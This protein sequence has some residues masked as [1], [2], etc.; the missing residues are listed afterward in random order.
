MA[1]CVCWDRGIISVAGKEIAVSEM[2]KFNVLFAL[3][4]CFVFVL[5]FSCVD[6]KIDRNLTGYR[7]GSAIEDVNYDMGH[8]ALVCYS[9]TTRI[10]E[11]CRQ[12]PLS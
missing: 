5:P 11:R 6:V 4:I 8:T 12:V 9:P 10:P 7:F 1:P 3:Y 2:L